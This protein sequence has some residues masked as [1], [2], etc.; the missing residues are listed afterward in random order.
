MGV[1]DMDFQKELQERVA[2]TEK[3]IGTYLPK[4]EGFQKSLLEA[5]KYSFLAGGT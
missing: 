5:M 3:V 4:E 1:Y 2:Y